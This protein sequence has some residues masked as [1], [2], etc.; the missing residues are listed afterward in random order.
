MTTTFKHHHDLPWHRVRWAATAFVLGAVLAA[1][2]T[3][4]LTDDTTTTSRPAASAASADSLTGAST[5][6][7]HVSADAA[8]RRSSV[9]AVPEP[10]SESPSAV[11]HR[12][13]AER[14]ARIALCSS[15]PISPDAAERCLVNR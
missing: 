15:G 6:I 13:E 9:Q 11:D 8:E 14:T 4:Q 1:G 10:L 2:L 7:D 5:G 3:V 12:V